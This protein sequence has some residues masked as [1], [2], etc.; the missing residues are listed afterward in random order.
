M[1][2]KHVNQYR[3]FVFKVCLHCPQMDNWEHMQ[4]HS[5]ILSLSLLWDILLAIVSADSSSIMLELPWSFENKINW[6]Y[7]LN[8]VIIALLKLASYYGPA[9]SVGCL[10][11]QLCRCLLFQPLNTDGIIAWSIHL[12]IVPT[13]LSPAVIPV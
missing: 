10:F 2:L 4:I 13:S 7:K 11:G 8:L 5:L 9:I 3:S 6:V 12:T 1:Y